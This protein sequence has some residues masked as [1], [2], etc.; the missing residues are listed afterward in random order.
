MTCRKTTNWKKGK[1]LKYGNKGWTPKYPEV[2]TPDLSETITINFTRRKSKEGD[3]SNKKSE[4]TFVQ[5]QS[6]LSCLKYLKHTF[7]K[8]ILVM[9]T[10]IQMY[11]LTSK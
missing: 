3:P 11:A 5:S 8:G 10:E 9:F 1:S 4:F 7:V 2:L 6:A